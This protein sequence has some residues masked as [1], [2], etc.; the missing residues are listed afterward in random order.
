MLTRPE[1]STTQR[2]VTLQVS[3]SCDMYQAPISTLDSPTL[4]AASGAG[5][6]QLVGDQHP[7]LRTLALQLQRWSTRPDPPPRIASSSRPCGASIALSANI[8]AE[9][10]LPSDAP[11]LVQV[12]SRGCTCLEASA[13]IPRHSSTAA[14]HR[15]FRLGPRRGR[16]VWGRSP[17]R[18]C[19]VPSRP[20]AVRSQPRGRTSVDHNQTPWETGGIRTGVGVT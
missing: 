19:P 20:A 11:R 4:K 12:T 17:G 3:S 8:D 1:A 5:S 10:R 7:C 6:A 16:R 13:Q 9:P 18:P 2:A 15:P 14:V